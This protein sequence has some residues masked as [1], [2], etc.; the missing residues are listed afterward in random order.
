MGRHKRFRLNSS[1]QILVGFALMI[2]IGGLLLMLPV[3]SRAGNATPFID[4]MFTAVSAGCVT[5]LIVF[6]TATYWSA[7]GQFVIIVLIQIGG[8]GII[9][10]TI[11]FARILG[12]RIGLAQRSTLQE[13]MSVPQIGGIVKLAGRIFRFTIIVEAAGALVM[14]PV[15]IRDFGPAGGAARAFFHSISAYC[16]A[17]FDL[18]GVTGPFSSLTHYAS[19]PVINVVIMLLILIGGLG[20]LTWG[21]IRTHRL[22]FRRYSTQS[23]IILVTSLILVLAPA[24]FL[25]FTEFVG[26]PFPLRIWESLFQSVTTRTAGFNTA[27]MSA[28]SDSSKL[29]TILLMLI[30][31]APGSTAGGMKMTT[32]AVLF[33]VMI[34]VFRREKYP[35]AHGRRLGSDVMR[36]AAAVFMLYMCMFLTGGLALSLIEGLPLLDTLFESASAVATVGL[37]TGIT[38]GLGTASKIILML[39]M[40]FGR[41][42]G[43]TMIFAAV[44]SKDSGNLKYP[45]DH[46]AVG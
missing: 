44:S 39:L 26:E 25:F 32:V 27:D 38:P 45:E 2:F 34:S 24:V 1:Q 8:L 3:S 30:G 29:I 23:K 43:L 9:T 40:Y 11:L 15:F 21:D 13:A 16:N 36:Q 7:F 12:R 19:Q 14:L 42:G 37:T 22:K 33:I 28:Y 5:G 35:A 4:A 18:M 6:D 46:V 41:V 20:F 17:G 31:G 10:M